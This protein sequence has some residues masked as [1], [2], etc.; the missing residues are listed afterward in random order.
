MTYQHGQ[1]QGLISGREVVLRHPGQEKGR[2][3]GREV[4]LIFIGQEKG[5]FSGREV[6]LRF[7]GQEKGCFYGREDQFSEAVHK[8]RHF[9][10]KPMWR[11]TNQ[12]SCTCR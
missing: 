7:I 6:V 1:E 4:V 11:G 3:S 5:L 9:M 12:S 2:F 10:D 8:T